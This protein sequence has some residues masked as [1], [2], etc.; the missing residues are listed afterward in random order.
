M[1]SLVLLA[2]AI[3]LPLLL[4]VALRVKPLYVFVSIVSGYFG[5]QFLG[6]VVELMVGSV[7]HSHHI[8]VI[9]RVVL[10]LAP[11]VVTLFLMRKT[12][13]AAALPFQ[14]ILLVADSLLLAAFLIPQLTPGVQG[15]LYLT[16]PGHIFQQAHDVMIT[17]IAGLHVL[18]MWIMRPRHQDGHG[19]HKK[20]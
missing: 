11:F 7:I 9:T 17:A 13:S 8:G 12:L 14:F 15:A 19:K 2:S 4:T 5:A 18:V 10:L 20:H 1:S 6:E 3:G 16:N